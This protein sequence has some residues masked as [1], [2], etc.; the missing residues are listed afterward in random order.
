MHPHPEAP[1]APAER[2]TRDRARG[3]ARGMFYAHL[4]L[5]VV[6]TGLVLLLSVTG[7][8]LNHKRP[9]G[10][11]PDV[12]NDRPAPLARSLP[13]AELARR[14]GL[15]V[16]AAVAAAGV[17]RMDVRPGDGL[18]KVRFDDPA[19]HEVTLDLASGRV[20]HVGERNDV[21]LE[22]LHT[23]E[24]FGENGVL[25]SDLAAV[26]L[27]VLAISGYWLWLRPRLRA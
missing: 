6:T 11:M 16:P 13:V 7:V 14:A 26:A 17:D 19:V 4:W 21:F 2:R 3:W 10:L 27:L 18:V 5:G 15:A 1:P 22:K 24:I 12:P 8:L 25:L 9:L 20:L 23:G